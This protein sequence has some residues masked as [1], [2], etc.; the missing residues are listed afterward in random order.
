MVSTVQP[1]QL[2][3]HIS[4]IMAAAMLLNPANLYN[5]EPRFNEHESSEAL[6]A[7]RTMLIMG[8]MTA[9]AAATATS[10]KTVTKP[11][12]TGCQGVQ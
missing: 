11:L 5:R 1:I 12:T 10:D 8:T 3:H 6:H 9:T 7:C 2:D 4:S